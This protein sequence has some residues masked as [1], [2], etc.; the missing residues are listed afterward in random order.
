MNKLLTLTACIIFLIGCDDN[1]NTAEVEQSDEDVITAFVESYE[2]PVQQEASI[3]LTNPENNVVV[4]SVNYGKAKDCPAGCFYSSAWGILHKQKIGWVSFSDYGDLESPIGDRYDLDN[5]D[6]YLYSDEFT[7]LLV[8]SEKYFF[9]GLYQFVYLKVSDKDTPYETLLGYAEQ[10]E[11]NRNMVGI[12]LGLISN[13]TVQNDATILTMLANLSP[14]Y[15][16]YSD[17]SNMAQEFLEELNQAVKHS[18][19]E[20]GA[21]NKLLQRTHNGWR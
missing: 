18:V 14:E 4:F 7:E 17:I 5:N 19:Y 10:V 9:Y 6:E 8:N 13:H 21:L 2:L 16:E 3:L 12:A 11:Q 1:K 15:S 20:F